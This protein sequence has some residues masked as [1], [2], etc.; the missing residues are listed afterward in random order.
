MKLRLAQPGTAGRHRPARRAARAS[1]SSTTGGLSDRRADDLRGARWPRRPR[2]YGVASRRPAARSA[3]SRSA[4]AG[5]SAAPSPTPIPASDLPAAL[6]ALD[7]ELVDPVGVG[8]TRIVP[9]DGFFEGAFTTGLAHDEIL[10][11]V[12]LPAPRDDAGIGLRV[13]RAAGV[14]LLDR[15]RGRRGRRRR[16][17]DDRVGRHRRDRRA[18]HPY[19]AHE[20][21]AGAGRHDGHGRRS[22][23]RRRSS[24][25]TASVNADIHAGR[26]YRA[27]MAVV[28]ARRAIEAALARAR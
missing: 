13:A 24:S 21:E 19:R 28:H 22:R 9:V 14:G 16:G 27:A 11:A 20:V 12:I 26:E 10:T 6:L 4:T 1:A 8:G 17:R 18:D 3:T 5:P 7:A 25:A 23:P 15:R 2:T